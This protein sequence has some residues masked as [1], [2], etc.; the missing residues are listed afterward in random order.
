[1]STHSEEHAIKTGTKLS[2]SSDD[3]KHETIQIYNT[4]KPSAS[5]RSQKN[6]IA[7]FYKLIFS[8]DLT[9]NKKYSYAENQN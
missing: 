8:F 5:S 4:L 7:K 9:K 3:K 6:V 1:M 2:S